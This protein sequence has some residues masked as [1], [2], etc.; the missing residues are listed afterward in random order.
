MPLGVPLPVGPSYP[1]AATHRYA[2]EHAPFDPLVTSKSD[3]ASRY[4]SCPY[5]DVAVL[6]ASAYT[7]AMIGAATLVPPK[8][9]HPLSYTATPV[10]GS[11]TAATS[12]I[13]RRLHPASCCHAGLAIYALQPLPAPLHAVSDQ[14]RALPSRRSVVPP[15]AVTKRDAAGNCGPNPASPLLAVIIARGWLK[16]A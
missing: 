12:A 2:D 7:P 6:A 1:G 14:P 3:P 8:M 11:A 4:E 16:C 13:E 15:T 5:V 9:Y 10:A